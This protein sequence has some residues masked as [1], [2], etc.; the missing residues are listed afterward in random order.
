MMSDHEK[1]LHSSKKKKKIQK[2]PHT[3]GFRLTML[4]SGVC[5]KSIEISLL[6]FSALTELRKENESKHYTAFSF[7]ERLACVEKKNC[8][9]KKTV[10]HTQKKRKTPKIKHKK[11]QKLLSVSQKVRQETRKV[12]DE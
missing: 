11:K 9:K 4:F 2:S 10:N 3:S 12:N 7:A 1:R 5:S 8:Q 6:S